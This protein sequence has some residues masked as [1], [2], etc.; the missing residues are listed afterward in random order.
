MYRCV[1][2]DID[3]ELDIDI[4]EYILIYISVFHFLNSALGFLRPSHVHNETPCTTVM[5]NKKHFKK[6]H[7][8]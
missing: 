8:V 4:N 1:D 7:G 6:A 3:L 5:Y 2:L